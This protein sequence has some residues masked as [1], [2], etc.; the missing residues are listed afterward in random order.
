MS[1]KVELLWPTPVYMN[2]LSTD[3]NDLTIAK[4]FKYE[5]MKSNN[6][7]YTLDKNVLD[8]MPSLKNRIETEFDNYVRNVLYIKKEIKF[9]LINSWINIHKKGDYAQSH[10]H[11]NSCFSGV[12]YLNA[13]ENSGDINFERSL[14]LT[15]VSTPTI[16]YD[17]D[18]VN[19]ISA[20]NVKFKVE[21]GVILFFPSTLY[22]NVDKSKS[23]IER[24]SLAF[25]FFVDGKIGNKESELRLKVL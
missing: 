18:E 7:D 11:K 25:N 20:D 1:Y 13:P 10:C 12:Y 5:R 16:Q 8:K 6:G 22:H 24:Y 21:N 2:K 9:K 17:Y 23:D 3:S 4:T 19:Y 14:S 15:N